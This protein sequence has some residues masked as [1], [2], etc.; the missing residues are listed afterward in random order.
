MKTH[1]DAID[2]YFNSL[3]NEEL[4]EEF[5]KISALKSKDGINYYRYLNFLNIGTSDII[6]IDTNDD[7]LCADFFNETIKN[8]NMRTEIYQVKL[9]VE[10][11][12]SNATFSCQQDD[13][14]ES[15]LFLDAA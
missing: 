13:N 4:E 14:F 9:P 12:G 6:D 11:I 5:L 3:S 7:I 1:L 8:V 10:N 15:E 2:D